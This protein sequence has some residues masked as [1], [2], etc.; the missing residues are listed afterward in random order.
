ME[1]IE[2]RTLSLMGESNKVWYTN[3]LLN[4][5]C[6]PGEFFRVFWLCHQM[7][8]ST[9]CKADMANVFNSFPRS[10]GS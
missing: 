10:S 2:R 8:Q 3:K 7:N 1:W 5:T 4:I 9:Q 6:V